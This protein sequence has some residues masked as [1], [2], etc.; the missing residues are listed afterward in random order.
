MRL[1]CLANHEW[2]D[3]ASDECSLPDEHLELLVL[4]V[5]WAA[6]QALA[7][8]E[9]AN[10]DPA[11]GSRSE[12]ESNVRSAENAFQGRLVSAV[13]SNASSRVSAWAA[14]VMGRVY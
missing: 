8:Q 1:R 5:R 10:P 14:A 4:F 7:T 9:A 13:T 3:T 11:G 2:L 12:L 6:W